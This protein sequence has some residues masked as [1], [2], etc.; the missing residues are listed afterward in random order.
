MK[1]FFLRL[2]LFLIPLSIYL[3]FI[4]LMDP[5][6]YF[7]LISVVN[8]NKKVQAFNRDPQLSMMG[9]MLWKLSEYDRSRCENIILGDSRVNWISSDTLKK[10]TGLDYY[11]F[12]TPGGDCGTFIS[13][14]WYARE[15]VKLKNVYI[16][17]SFHN[18]GVSWRK[19]LYAEATEIRKKVYPF[20]ISPLFIKQALWI[21]KLAIKQKKISWAQTDK[22]GTQI[23]QD[24]T[25]YNN[26]STELQKVWERKVNEQTNTFRLYKYPDDY[27]QGLLN[28]S[29]YC[30]RN[31]INLVF[32]ILPNYK[33]VHD[34][35]RQAGLE[36][37]MD[38]FKKDIRSLGETYDF[39]Y[40]NEITNTQDYYYDILHFNWLIYSIINREIWNH[41]KGIA[42]H[43][44]PQ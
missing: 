27:Y 43:T 8:N 18:Y 2:S 10:L 21:S 40:S 41:E 11:N 26:R 36:S 33:E 25:T 16:A 23:L 5:F 7:H 1:K 32:L 39:D 28:V 22:A 38:R 24:K 44:F 20:F 12:G 29:A 17:V 6:N 31:D 3:G 30:T 14:F 13:L 9:T 4:I 37:E 35:A 15:R 34:L 42:I 19:D